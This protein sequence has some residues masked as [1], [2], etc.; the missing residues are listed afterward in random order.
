MLVVAAWS[1]M[2]MVGGWAKLEPLNNPN[3]RQKI[4][5]WL[6]RKLNRINSRQL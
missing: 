5:E 4:I 3:Y 6:Q 1:L 2:D